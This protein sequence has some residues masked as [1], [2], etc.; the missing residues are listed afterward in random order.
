MIMIMIMRGRGKALQ[1]L[2]IPMLKGWANADRIKPRFDRILANRLD[3]NNARYDQES[4]KKERI[5]DAGLE[6]LQKGSSSQS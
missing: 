1:I 6:K 2:Y 4:R 5:Q 3:Y